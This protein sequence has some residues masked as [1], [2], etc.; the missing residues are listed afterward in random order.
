MRV[1][2]CDL[3]NTEQETH[4]QRER[5]RTGRRPFRMSAAVA[6][7]LGLL[8]MTGLGLASATHLTV[9]STGMSVFSDA[10]C[11]TATLSVHVSPTGTTYL[12]QYNKSAVSIVNYPA[13]CD[14]ATVQVVVANSSGT[15]LATG[16]GTCNSPSCTISTGSY[17]ATNAANAS[18]LVSTWGVA[19]SWDSVCTV[20][21]FLNI[22]MD[23]T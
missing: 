11:S 22:R 5:T 1:E 18:V 19:A 14:G 13:A 16:S 7:A 21:G 3:V 10:P 2:G 9:S 6:T 12:W 20:G 15:A 4:A 17:N 23:C 8:L